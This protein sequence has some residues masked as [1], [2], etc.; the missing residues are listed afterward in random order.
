MISHCFP[1]DAGDTHPKWPMPGV[2]VLPC[3]ELAR[4][5][6][7]HGLLGPLSLAVSVPNWQDGLRNPERPACGRCYK[8]DSPM[9]TQKH[10]QPRGLGQGFG[11]ERPCPVPLLPQ[12]SGGSS[13][14]PWGWCG[15][16]QARPG[17]TAPAHPQFHA[18]VVPQEAEGLSSSAQAILEARPEP[19]W[20]LLVTGFKKSPG[21]PGDVALP[22][23]QVL[24]QVGHRATPW[25]PG[26]GASGHT[27]HR[28][29][30]SQP[31]AKVGARSTPTAP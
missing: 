5:P 1:L 21:G 4:P 15:V 26:A 2:L 18:T 30:G 9:M 27:S 31:R 23:S 22:H 12:M 11:L 28:P 14:P 6:H 20:P 13:P 8:L 24:G 3:S 16:G 10:Q 19:L 17:S 25:A 29:A 7:M